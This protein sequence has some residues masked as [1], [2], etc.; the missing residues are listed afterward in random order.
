MKLIWIKDTKVSIYRKL[1]C[2]HYIDSFNHMNNARYLELFEEARW[3]ICQDLVDAIFKHNAIFVIVNINIDY[4]YPANCQDIV[5]IDAKLHAI[6]NT[7][8]VMRQTM[9]NEKTAQLL[10]KADFTMV[11]LDK[12]TNRPKKINAPLREVFDNWVKQ[13]QDDLC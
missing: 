7:S 2:G 12:N 4:K 6:N 10:A 13:T 5:L 8:F 3:T 1:I 9:V 11:L